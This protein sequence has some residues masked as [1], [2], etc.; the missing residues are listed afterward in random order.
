MPPILFH[1][2]CDNCGAYAFTDKTGPGDLDDAV[3]CQTPAGT[4]PGS[5]DGCCATNG[6]T[7]EQHIARVREGGHLAAAAR[8]VTVTVGPGGPARI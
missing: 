4:P 6:M 3:R 7:H 5:V 2:S 1:V 8:P